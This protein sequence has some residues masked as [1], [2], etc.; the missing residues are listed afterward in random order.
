M[1]DESLGATMTVAFTAGRMVT[2]ADPEGLVSAELVALMVTV[3]GLGTA[4]GAVYRPVD[5][6]VPTVELPPRMLFTDHVNV[7]LFLLTMVAVN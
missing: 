3:A 5:V 2:M 7:V 6:I 1:V 4:A